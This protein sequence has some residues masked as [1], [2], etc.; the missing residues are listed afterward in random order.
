MERGSL[1]GTRK[2]AKDYCTHR[3]TG[4]KDKCHQEASL[5][6]PVTK[7]MTMTGGGTFLRQKKMT[8]KE[9]KF[10]CIFLSHLL[11]AFGGDCASKIGR[12]DLAPVVT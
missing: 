10:Y 5:K 7:K 3:G 12:T 6:F 4:R 11:F 9:I 2:T 1:I 8:E